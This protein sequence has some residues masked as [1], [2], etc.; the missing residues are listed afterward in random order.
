[1]R[2][3]CEEDPVLPRRIDPSL[4]GD[5]QNVCMKA[6][7][8]DPANRY[9]SAREMAADLERFLAGEAVVAAP[10][11]YSRR[12]GGKVAQHLQELEGW[13]QERR[14]RRAGM[15]TCAERWPSAP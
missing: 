6:L 11:S 2:K 12:M 1:M 13:R 7:E 10:A 5:L 9:G 4:P 14:W 8:K 3:I 15:T